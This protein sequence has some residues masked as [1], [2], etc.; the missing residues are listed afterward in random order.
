MKFLLADTRERYRTTLG[1]ME[2]GRLASV[3]A[4]WDNALLGFFF[5]ADVDRA[6]F[7]VRDTLVP[8]LTEDERTLDDASMRELLDTVTLDKSAGDVASQIHES[9]LTS[10]PRE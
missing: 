5:G 9:Y 4:E 6:H 8:M 3:G 2:G 10:S 7:S 1:R